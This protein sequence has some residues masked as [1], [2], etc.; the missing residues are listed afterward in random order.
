VKDSPGKNK[1]T[2]ESLLSESQVFTGKELIEREKK[3]VRQK[4][5]LHEAMEFEERSRKTRSNNK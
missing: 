5:L 2:L 4:I 3:V 1:P